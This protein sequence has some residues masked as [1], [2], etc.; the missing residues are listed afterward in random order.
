MLGHV[1]LTTTQIYTQVSIRRLK[2]VHALTHPGARLAVRLA[3][4][5]APEHGQ[6][7]E[8][9]DELFRRLAAEGDE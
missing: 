8:Q 9:S 1:E 6:D 7:D 2:E 3:K 5:H 4:A